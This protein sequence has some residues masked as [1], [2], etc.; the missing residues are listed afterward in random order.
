MFTNP[1]K[2]VAAAAAAADGRKKNDENNKRREAFL[3]VLLEPR[4]APLSADPVHGPAITALT[5]AWRAA[6]HGVATRM[7][8]SASPPFQLLRAGGRG[9]NFDFTLRFEG[10]AVAFLE[11]KYGGSSIVEIPEF[12][13]PAENKAFLGP[14]ILYARTWYREYLD[15][16]LQLL[17]RG[18]AAA[19]KP[20]ED[21]YLA[22]V[23]KNSANDIP[24]FQA[25]AHLHV[26]DMPSEA[27]TLVN[28]SITTFLQRH[29]A[30]TDIALLSSEFQRSQANKFFLIY[31]P[32]SGIFRIDTIPP[33]A[34]TVVGPATVRNGNLLC[35]NSGHPAF[36][37]ELLLRWKN[38]KGVLYPAWQIRLKL[39]A[40]S[41]A[42]TPVPS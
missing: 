22:N 33:E 15:R 28:E 13:N 24:F 38:G 18:G 37:Y 41:E 12:F 1:P 36:C 29:Y 31:D 11:F 30:T 7:G 17:K 5:E 40:K 6:I 35:V 9:K 26:E 8:L 39:R 25:L 20:A 14:D 10:G 42:P 27:N 19:A 34:L 3:A 32:S 4:A 2:D 23:Y 21:V 16:F